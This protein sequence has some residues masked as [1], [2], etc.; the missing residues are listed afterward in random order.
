MKLTPKMRRHSV[1]GG[2][3]FAF[4]ATP[5]FAIFG[6]GDIVFDP[7]SYASLISQL[8]TLKT[9]YTML[10]NNLVHFS[11]KNTWQTEKNQLEHMPVGNQFGET[12]G[13]D[14]ALTSNNSAAAQS[15]WRNATVQTNGNA[16]TY[17]ASQQPGSAARSQLASIESTDA[18]SAECIN[19]VGAYRAAVATNAQAESNLQSSQMDGSGDTNTEVEQ[20]NLVNAAQAQQLVE[21]KQQG[22]LHACLAQQMAMASMQQRNAAADDLNTKGFV[23]QQHQT[24]SAYATGGSDTWTTYLP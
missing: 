3:L 7:T 18:T 1:V 24:N 9:Q 13:I 12:A 23:A 8:T 21:L 4:V 5:S 17:V 11:W 19:A 15:A 20:L 22:M 6:I 16:T 2:V 14:V 10:Q